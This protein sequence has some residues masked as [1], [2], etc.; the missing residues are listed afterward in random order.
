[1]TKA[2]WRLFSIGIVAAV[3]GAGWSLPA[4]A[5]TA[6]FVK[7]PTSTAVPLGIAP[8]PDG[9]IWIAEHVGNKIAQIT[10]SGAV[11][12]FPVPTAAGGPSGI[13]QG[14]DGN[15]WFTEQT[16]G[17]IGRI[18]PSGVITEFPVPSGN[19]VAP[20]TRGPDGNLWFG[21]QT[22]NMVG[23]IT[24]AGVIS[25]FP[26]PTENGP[27]GPTAITSGP[28][29][30]IWFTLPGLNSIGRITTDGATVNT[31][32]IPTAASGP[33][34][35]ALGSDGNLYFT[36]SN[37]DKIGQV[38][39]IV[40]ITGSPLPNDTTLT[41]TIAEFQLPSGTAPFG[42]TFGPQGTL[43]FTAL[44]SN[45]LYQ[46]ILPLPAPL[47]NGVPGQPI[48]TQFPLSQSCGP[49]AITSGPLT[50]PDMAFSCGDVVLDSIG[51]GSTPAD[52]T[53]TVQLP[54]TGF[55]SVTSIPGGIKCQ[56]LPGLPGLNDT[57][58][59]SFPAGQPVAL[60]PSASP[61]VAVFAGWNLPPAAAVPGCSGTMTRCQFGLGADTTVTATF[62]PQSATKQLSI[63]L[64]GPELWVFGPPGIDCS[65]FVYE[66]NFNGLNINGSNGSGH[67]YGDGT[68]RCS[69]S[70]PTGTVVMLKSTSQEIG[71]PPV[72]S[73]GG[74]SGRP[75]CTIT[76]LADTEVTALSGKFGAV[77]GAA[78]TLPTDR[79]ALV[80]NSS[81]LVARPSAGGVAAG[82]GTVTI[83]GTMINTLSMTA[84]NCAVQPSPLANLPGP[85]VYQTTNP[86]TNALTGTANTPVNIPAG[87]AQSFVL[88]FTP[89]LPFAPIDVPL[90]FSC[91]NLLAAPN[92]SGLDTVLLAAST[93][94][95]PDV[96]ALG[97]TAT[98]DQILHITGSTG[99][100]AFA[101][102]TINLGAGDTITAAANTGVSGI[103]IGITLCQTNPQSGQCLA[104]PST[105]VTTQI[106]SNDTPT[107]GVFVMA[108]DSVLFDPTDNRI[109]VSF[110]DSTG[111]Q[112]G[113][114]SVA[115][116]TQ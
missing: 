35:I 3:I 32:A 8:G 54:G 115:V 5:Q 14:P 88:A 11:T 1:M 111:T 46:M 86:A 96:I 33:A 37:T 18:T 30:A 84:T 97:A 60:F 78:A 31:F 68:G 94:P 20:I 72:L 75:S 26:L 66:V 23:R 105:S 28:D 42:I 81:A 34:G 49:S 112:R 2:I 15:L 63:T 22:A 71:L 107:F 38:A 64:G 91:A 12:E 100:A 113:G 39:P 106:N 102:A 83:F 59:A 48:M 41:G 90:T 10:P 9:N 109:F 36:E 19:S 82:S 21:E 92:N 89:T 101:V 17:K 99:S 4:G 55:G 70:F 51:L 65:S 110:S 114:T 40:T 57:C 116:E 85:F 29:G 43:W 73:G 79:N 56:N 108:L 76:L 13:T 77:Y 50:F 52:V 87:Q 61:T 74:C 7:L 95:V 27:G 67:G 16:A 69:A 80:T 44:G 62:N 93:T 104:A 53:L 45:S 47:T 24:T 103:P 98:N 25:E 6:T 58:S